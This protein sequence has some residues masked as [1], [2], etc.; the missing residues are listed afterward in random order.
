MNV[1]FY[2][3]KVLLFENGKFRISDSE[4]YVEGDIITYVGAGKEEKCDFD[5]QIDLKGNLLMTG[6][7]NAHTHSAM[8]FLRSFADDLPLKEWLYNRVFPMEAKLS[9]EHIY[10]FSK[11]AFMEYLTSGITSCFDMYYEPSAMAKSSVDCGFR[12]VMCGAV[13]D[14]KES[15]EKLE[16]YYNTFNKF[17]PL[18]TYRLG[19]HAEYTTS[20]NILSEIAKLS[21]KY[22][23]PVY[24]HLCETENEVDECV[25]RHGMTPVR[26]LDSLGI[27]NNGGGGFHGVYLTEEDIEI[28]KRRN[29]SIVTNPAS[30]LK[31][32]SGIAPISTLLQ[33]GINI[34]IGTDGPASNNCLDM[35]REMFLVTALQKVILKDAS[36][37]PAEDVLK[38]ACV[39]GAYVMGLDNCDRIAVGKKADLTVLDMSSPNMQPVNN[40]IKNIVY[41][42]SKSN[43]LLTMINGKILFENGEFYIGE[44]A[45]KICRDAEK[46]IRDLK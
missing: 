3:G 17:N 7:K 40:T 8:T 46:L 5:R 2:N 38:M 42:G 12:T 35:F 11:I 13:N 26:F 41:S 28:I 15:P 1:R 25:S 6:F 33:N 22:N 23:A 31:L 4:V 32:A 19:F 21:E 18:V 16:D 20:A 36:T 27:F 44:S 30:N 45:E 43:I 29:V 24:T 10:V 37:C 9:D 39:N 34:A 14:F